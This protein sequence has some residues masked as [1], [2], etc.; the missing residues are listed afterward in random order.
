MLKYYITIVVRATN[1]VHHLECTSETIDETIE[2][3]L[4]SWTTHSAT[5][6][7]VNKHKEEFF[8]AGTTKDNSKAFSILAVW[9]NITE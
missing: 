5:T 9:E 4:G 3:E 7:G 6:S 1:T 2:K 8:Q